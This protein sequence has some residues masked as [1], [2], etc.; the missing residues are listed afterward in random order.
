[1]FVVGATSYRVSAYRVPAFISGIVDGRS[2]GYRNGGI[3]F[4]SAREASFTLLGFSAVFVYGFLLWALKGVTKEE[5][6]IIL[7]G[8]K[9]C[10]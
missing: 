8:R 10:S 2:F 9:T 7:S 4:L 3:P 1:M 5:V 6:N